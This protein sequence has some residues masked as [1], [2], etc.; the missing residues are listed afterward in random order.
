MRS[1]QAILASPRARACITDIERSGIR[2]KWNRQLLTSILV[3]FSRFTESWPQVDTKEKA[4]LAISV[5]TGER[6]RRLLQAWLSAREN[7]N[8]RN[9]VERWAVFQQVWLSLP[10]WVL[11]PYQS[12]TGV[13]AKLN[14]ML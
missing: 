12:K 3:Y 9:E 1:R 10:V 5:S 6:K 4:E 8:R 7:E 13:S 2:S 11:A 14:S